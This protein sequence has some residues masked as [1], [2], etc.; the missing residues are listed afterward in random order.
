MH[1]MNPLT[2]SLCQKPVLGLAMFV[3][4]MCAFPP[5]FPETP[6]PLHQAG[7]RVVE[8]VE[9]PVGKA[10]FLDLV[11]TFSSAAAA[12][13]DEVVGSRFD[14]ICLRNVADIPESRR[15]GLGRPIPIH[16]QVRDQ[17]SGTVT[18]DKVFHSLCLNSSGPGTGGFT[19]HRTAGRLDL[20]AGRYIVEVRNMESQA[21]LEG[22]RTAVS[23]VAGQGK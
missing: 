21:G 10:Y 9:A 18:I 19:K 14:D 4:G 23:L 1:R 11:F 8:Q 13:D 22:V 7:A 2:Y 20:P 6:L 12:R 17:K 5:L 15:Y 3:T 16:V